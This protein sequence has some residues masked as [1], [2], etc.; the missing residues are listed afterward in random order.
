MAENT[1]VLNGRE[2]GLVLTTKA[3]R[4][5]M[6]KYGSFDKISDLFKRKNVNEDELLDMIVFLTCTFV[7]QS[8]LRRNFR[9]PPGE[10]E[11]LMTE[12]EV[13]LFTAIDDLF[14]FL[15]TITRVLLNDAKQH[16]GTEDSEKKETAAQ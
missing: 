16:V 15:P 7:N 11:P 8:I 4:D 14:E 12:G 9:V 13:E 1:I 10:Q 2:Y 3:A 5:I 6:R